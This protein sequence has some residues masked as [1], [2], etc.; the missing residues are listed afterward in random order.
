MRRVHGP[1]E[2]CGEGGFT[3]IE[4]MVV[5]LII[6]IL[7]AI[8]LPTYLGA[9]R[10]ASDRAAQS[11]LRTGLAAAMTY[12]SGTTSYSGFTPSTAKAFEASIRWIGAAPPNEGEVS[13]SAASGDQ[14]LLVA[15]S[16]SG[17]YWCVA[18]IPNSPATAKGQGAAYTDVNT[19]PQCTG[20]W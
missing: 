8:A 7:I 16:S 14:L 13:I 6:G 4:L 19:I 9:R 2:P 20:G 11:N 5:V 3:L 12:Y 10:T 17:T 18:E 15:L 1:G